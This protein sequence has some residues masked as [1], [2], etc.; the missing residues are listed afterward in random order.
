ML[1]V[2]RVPLPVFEKSRHVVTHPAGP[3]KDAGLGK[4]RADDERDV[5]VEVGGSGSEVPLLPRR[6]HGPHDLRV[7][8]RH[9]CA[10][11]HARL[12]LSMQSNTSAL[13][14]TTSGQCG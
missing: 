9:A 5:W 8:L 4:G 7:V 1:G 3:V 2:D 12:L 14:E 13:R 6:V 11:S 10:A